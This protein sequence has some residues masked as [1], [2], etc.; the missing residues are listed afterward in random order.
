MNIGGDGEDRMT[1]SGNVNFHL[2]GLK[3][4]P[5]FNE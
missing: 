5:N 1:Y 2:I 4:K 3:V